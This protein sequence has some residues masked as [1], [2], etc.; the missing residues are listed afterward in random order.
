MRERN[1]LHQ[2]LEGPNPSLCPGLVYLYE[3]SEED[4]HSCCCNEE[5][6]PVEVRQQENQREA[7]GPSEPPVGNDELVLAGDGV[8]VESV[9][10]ES[11]HQNP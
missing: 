5:L 4:D 2:I 9:H 8:H 3:H 10:K 1:L 11:Q 6:F 7:N